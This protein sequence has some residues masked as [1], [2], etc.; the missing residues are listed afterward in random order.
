MLQVSLEKGKKTKKKESRGRWRNLRTLPRAG[1]SL[2]PH[3][4]FTGPSPSRASSINPGRKD[5]VVKTK[6]TEQ[7]HRSDAPSSQCKRHKSHMVTIILR[8]PL[9]LV[10]RADIGV[11]LQAWTVILRTVGSSRPLRYKWKGR[12]KVQFTCRHLF[13]KQFTLKTTATFPFTILLLL[14]LHKFLVGNEGTGR[15]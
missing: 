1:I 6:P 9:M 2:A 4:H 15:E 10:D 14:L 3:S 11:C 8:P 5:L 7:S 13:S 12:T